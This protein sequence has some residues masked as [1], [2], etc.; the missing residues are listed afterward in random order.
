MVERHGAQRLEPAAGFVATAFDF[1]RR[2]THISIATSVV[3]AS[4][5]AVA[6]TAPFAPNAPLQASPTIPVG[7]KSL[8]SAADVSH[9]ARTAAASRH[10]PVLELVEEDRIVAEADVRAR[11]GISTKQRGVDRR[12][13][14]S[15]SDIASGRAASREPS[16]AARP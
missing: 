14:S 13:L 5:C 15:G 8:Q 7:A 11:D 4:V 10:A 9:D 6:L 2:A 12:L 3:S 1:G 16:R